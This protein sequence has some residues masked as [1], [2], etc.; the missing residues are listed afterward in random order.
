MMTNLRSSAR[1]SSEFC[2]YNEVVV[3]CVTGPRRAS[4]NASRRDALLHTSSINLP[5]NILT[6]ADPRCKCTM[7]AT[8]AA[9][10]LIMHQWFTYNIAMCLRVL[11]DAPPAVT[12]YILQA[13][14]LWLE[15]HQWVSK[16]ETN[17]YE[18]HS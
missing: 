16:F 11:R 1:P 7:Y 18:Y 13:R 10:R 6:N 5:V 15:Q 9:R 2:R 8:I 3:R 12:R 4:N 17:I 14:G